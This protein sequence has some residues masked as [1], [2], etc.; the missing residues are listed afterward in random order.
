MTPARGLYIHIPFC[1]QKCGY[2]DF[3][4]FAGIENQ[5][6]AYLN[7]LEKEAALYGEVCFDT[8]YI[9]GG[10]PSLLSLAQLKKLFQ[11]ISAKWGEVGTF[12][13]STVEANPESLTEEKINFLK[14]AGV[15]RLSIG[16][17]SFSDDILKRIGRI[18]TT[19]MFEQA[20]QSA[21]LAGFNNINV[22]LIA[23]LPEQN[24]KQFVGGLKKLIALRPEHISVYALQVEEGT[25]FYR[26]GITADEDLVRKEWE[27][28][29]F[30]LAEKGY[31][32]Y[33]ISN[34]ARAGFE[35]KHNLNYWNNGEYVGLGSAAASYQNGTR[36]NNISSVAAYIA[37]VQS[38]KSPTEFA[39]HLTG[40]AAA[41]EQI[42]LGLRKLGG[43]RLSA[44]Q[45]GLFAR[46]IGDL[47]VRGLVEQNGDL[48]KLTFEGMFLANQAFV[49]F[50]GPF[51]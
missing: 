27:Q 37:C 3:A 35:S 30:L 14:S 24:E 38:G 17:Q 36:R 12:T 51:D 13:E 6:D 48:L 5:I 32:H 25:P 9:G 19:E 41:G 50:V 43:V 29:H 31:T 20:Y 34:F 22:D 44:E 15:N 45:Q 40:K 2:C 47:C 21:R 28:A 46:E 49:E 11:I 16:L 7:A 10:T 4:S 39:E 18:H 1:K 33:E 42:M 23:G 26:T 8:L